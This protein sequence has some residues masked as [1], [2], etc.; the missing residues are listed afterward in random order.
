MSSNVSI[1]KDLNSGDVCALYL[2]HVI[3]R[4]IVYYICCVTQY[5]GDFAYAWKQDKS[6]RC[7]CG[8]H[9]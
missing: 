8:T 4:I 9:I 6:L 2:L 5:S 3:M 1:R 7:S